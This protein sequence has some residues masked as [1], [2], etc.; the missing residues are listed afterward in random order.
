M[1][2]YL[3]WVILGAILITAETIVPGGI[4][5]FLGTSAVIV[6]LLVYFGVITN[7]VTAFIT[8]F[9]ISIISM[10]FLRSLFMKYFEGETS[11]DNV[12]EDEDILGKIVEVSEL[13]EPHKEGRIRFGD[14]TWI[15]RS[16]D[17]LTTDDKAVITGRDGNKFIVKAI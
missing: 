12:N 17:T 4:V 2:M 7:V 6:G 15:A 1:K 11:I 5:V 14:S 13:I 8:W 10:L 3:A 16:D 9:I